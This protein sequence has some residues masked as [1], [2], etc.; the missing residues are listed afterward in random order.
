VQVRI[1]FY[2]HKSRRSAGSKRKHEAGAVNRHVADFNQSPYIGLWRLDESEWL[3]KDE[4]LLV[5][6]DRTEAERKDGPGWPSNWKGQCC[7][8]HY[9]PSD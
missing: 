5:G 2:H 1:G 3:T 8:T 6:R 7:V 4:T 9:D